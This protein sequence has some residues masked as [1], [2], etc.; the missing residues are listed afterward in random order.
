M[1]DY[2]IKV[3]QQAENDTQVSTRAA[4]KGWLIDVDK[5]TTT[6]STSTSDAIRIWNLA[7]GVVTE[8]KTLYQA[9]VAIKAFVKNLPI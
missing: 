6:K 3:K 9:R 5:T 4:Q 1:E 8:S 7:P 2:P